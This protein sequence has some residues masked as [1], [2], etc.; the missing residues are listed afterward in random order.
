MTDSSPRPYRPQ[1]NSTTIAQRIQAVALIEAGI[2]AKIVAATVEVSDQT[3]YKWRRIAIER[4]YDPNV[5]KVL[6]EEYVTDAPRSGRPRKVNPEVE[7]AI[8]DNIPM[9]QNGR[10]QPSAVCFFLLLLSSLH[11]R[12][13]RDLSHE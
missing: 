4:G 1:S 2:A 11:C 13:Q 9:S 5:S 10:E 6:K 8:L 3:V 7:E 12:L